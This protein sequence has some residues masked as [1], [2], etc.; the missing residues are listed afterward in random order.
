MPQEQRFLPGMSPGLVRVAEA[1]QRNPGRLLSLAHHLKV[2]A[3]RRAFHRI[4]NNAAVGAD[5]VT[6]EEYGQAL[7]ENLRDLHQRLKSMRYRHQ[8]IRRVY[9][10]KEGNRKRPIGISTVE[11]KIVQEALRELLQVIYEQDFLD[12]SYGYRP[13]RQA[14]DALR[15]LD[16]AVHRGQVN[17]ILEADIV[18]FFDRIDR[19][20]L[21][22]LLQKRL[23]DKSL[24]RL[25]GKC[26][27]VGILDHGNSLSPETGTVQGSTLSPL[28]ANV[29]LHHVLDLWF[30]QEVKPQLRGQAILLRYADDFLIGFE[31]REEAKQVERAL[32]QRLER[33]KLELHPVKTRLVDFRRP[34]PDHQGPS[35]ET[36][37][38]LGFTVLWKRSR[39]G[40]KGWYMATFTR[41]ARLRRAKKAVNDWCRGH[42]HQPVKAQHAALEQRIKGHCN[43]YGVRGNEQRLGKLIHAAER[44]WFKWLNRRS[45]RSTMTWERFRDLLEDYPLPRP[46]AHLALWGQVQ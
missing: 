25:I 23:A 19:K 46:R 38:F 33:W 11:D 21:K 28:L 22:E 7:E 44:T 27:H 37:D 6:K 41:R 35:P 34:P 9:I 15:A 17:W 8:P 39:K 2:E 24:M 40:R 5:G 10:E 30:E 31:R 20:L 13:G 3:L 32:G 16:Q 45:Q 42:R 18:S 12:C 43:Y 1:A 14:H 4:R 29:Y 26:L 36:F